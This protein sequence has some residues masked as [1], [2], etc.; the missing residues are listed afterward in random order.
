M[1]VIN[2]NGQLDVVGIGSALLDL[3]VEV[4]DAFLADLNL[5]KGQMHLIDEDTSREIQKKIASMDIEVAPGGS[6]ANTLAG[7]V[8][9]GGSSLLL[10]CVG[11]DEHG[12]IYI[13]KTQGQG[14]DTSI[15][16]K[17][18]L[19]GHAITFITPDAERTFATH[20]GAALKFNDMDVLEEDIQKGKVLHLEGYLFEPDGLH[21]ACTKAMK[22][23]RAKG[24]GI[25]IDL[26]D[27]GLIGR[28]H[29]R[30]KDA[31]E[32]YVSIVFVNEE[33]ATAY[34]GKPPE[35]A[36][37][38]LGEVCECAVV[39]LGSEGSLIRFGGRTYEIN[40][41]S[42]DVVN[43]NGAGDMYAAGILYGITH[44]YSMEEAGILASHAAAKVVS[45]VPARLSENIDPDEVIDM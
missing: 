28:I 4:D 7:V 25:S 19:T 29:G 40:P 6:A 36:L 26:S 17:S 9:F 30:F 8:N 45:Q 41:E 11:D 13:E 1:T 35:E 38:E 12:S 39:K 20:L 23:A 21:F 34:T 16:R 43:T 22:I 18:T 2:E 33:E 14:V 5:T 10:G 31:L 3:I 27:P 32:K 44:G 24:L 15:E 42:A 37:L